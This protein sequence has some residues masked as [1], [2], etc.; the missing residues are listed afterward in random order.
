MSGPPYSNQA[1]IDAK[2]AE[3]QAE[4]AQVTTAISDVLKGG[5][6]W[7]IEGRNVR[8][9]DLPQ[10]REFRSKLEQRLGFLHQNTAGEHK[11][12][13]PFGTLSLHR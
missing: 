11:P 2:R 6:S 4:L 5:Q 3:L 13:T 7:A 1:E 12:I 10:L 8:L 9:A